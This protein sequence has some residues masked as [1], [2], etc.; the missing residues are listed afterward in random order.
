[1]RT[2]Q[3]PLKRGRFG[4]QESGRERGLCGLG[5]KLSLR[6]K[7]LECRGTCRRSTCPWAGTVGRNYPQSEGR[8]ERRRST[9]RDGAHRE[10]AVDSAMQRPPSRSV[11][12]HRSA[13]AKT[14]VTFGYTNGLTPQ[15]RRPSGAKAAAAVERRSK[16]KC[17]KTQVPYCPVRHEGDTC[18]RRT[19]RS[20]IRAAHRV[21]L[22]TIPASAEDSRGSG[23]PANC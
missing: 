17:L 21:R 11:I 23:A 5:A 3:G 19:I 22:R 16:P 10:C 6:I 15:Q 14:A 13:T 1:M 4:P 2:S 8:T 12:L 7:V 9:L 18:C 20:E